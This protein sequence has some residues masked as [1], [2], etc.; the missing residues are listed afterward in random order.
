[1]AQPVVEHVRLERVVRGLQRA[2]IGPEPLEV[3][4]TRGRVGVEV[5]FVSGHKYGQIGEHKGLFVTQARHA[6]KQVIQLRQRHLRMH[7]M[8]PEAPAAA[9]SQVGHDQLDQIREIGAPQARK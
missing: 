8:V 1:M 7:G 9:D 5:H 2:R 3:G 6:A 4:L